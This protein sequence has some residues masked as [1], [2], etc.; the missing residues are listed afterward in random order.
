LVRAVLDTSVLVAAM[1][2]QDGASYRLLT[3]VAQGA[4]TILAS[5]ALFLEYEDVLL[6]PSQIRAHGLSASQIHRILLALA[7][8]SNRLRST[9]AGG[10]SYP[11]L[12]MS[13]CSIS[14]STAGPMRS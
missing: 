2:S 6:R 11:I 12:P 7:N 14:R 4:L 13:L 1:R 8:C 10:L 5:P 9:T 3:H